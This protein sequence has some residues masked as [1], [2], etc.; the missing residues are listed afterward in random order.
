MLKEPS[1]L[2][3]NPSYTGATLCPDQWRRLASWEAVCWASIGLVA[4][5]LSRTARR[6]ALLTMRAIIGPIRDK[7]RR[8]AT[9]SLFDS[10]CCFTD[11]LHSDRRVFPAGSHHRRPAAADR[12]RSDL[13]RRRRPCDRARDQAGGAA[14]AR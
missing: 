3:S 1:A 13:A 4:I 14:R 8:D 11:F 6:K 7:I 12:T 9:V 5:A 2:T 10:C